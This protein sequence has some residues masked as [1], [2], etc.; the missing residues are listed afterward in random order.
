M[1][2]KDEW[3]HPVPSPPSYPHHPNKTGRVRLNTKRRVC[4]EGSVINP[5]GAHA[6]ARLS[7]LFFPSHVPFVR[8]GGGCGG[9]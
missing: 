4:R 9:V 2:P 6:R 7:V 8:D 5:G 3:T 1:R